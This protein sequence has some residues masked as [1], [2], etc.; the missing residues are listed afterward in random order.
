MIA[1]WPDCCAVRDAIF[2]QVVRAVAQE[3]PGKIDLSLSVI[4][5]LDRVLLRRIGVGQH[6]V[7][8]HGRHRRDRDAGR[9]VV[10]VTRIPVPRIIQI[11]K[12]VDHHERTAVAIRPARPCAAVVVVHLKH[13]VAIS[14]DRRN[15]F[16]VVPE[17]PLVLAIGQQDSG[18]AVARLKCGPVFCH[19]D[20][21]A[22]TE[23]DVAEL[24]RHTTINLCPVQVDVRGTGVDQLNVFVVVATNRVVHDFTDAQAALERRDS[25]RIDQDRVVEPHPDRLHLLRGDEH[26]TVV[27]R[28]VRAECLDMHFLPHVLDFPL[29]MQLVT[30][31]DDPHGHLLLCNR[32]GVNRL[33]ITF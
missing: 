23:S 20:P 25:R 1:V 26:S 4:V 15:G 16:P 27:G 7:D 18:L 24:V 22:H 33:G 12:R 28:C 30:M 9:A 5:Q 13:E 31:P 14:I 2:F 21:F 8:H 6:L 3:P 10:G 17:T 19:N 32:L 29:E 11:T